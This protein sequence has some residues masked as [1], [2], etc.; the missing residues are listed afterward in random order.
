MVKIVIITSLYIDVHDVHDVFVSHR[1]RLYAMCTE[2]KILRHGLR[3]LHSGG[4]LMFPDN[5][6]NC[7]YYVLFYTGR[8]PCCMA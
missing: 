5:F 6:M 1:A 7:R 2:C 3:L 4:D 8:S